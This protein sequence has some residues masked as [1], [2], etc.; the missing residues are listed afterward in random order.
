MQASTADMVKFIADVHLGRLA[1]ILRML[2]FDTVY[3]NSFP[4]TEMLRI[5]AAENRIVLSRNAALA[6]NKAAVAAFHIRSEDV[7][8]QIRSVINSFALEPFH[9][10]S[11]CMVCNGLLQAVKKESINMQLEEN[12]TEYFND[13]WQ[14]QNCKKIFWKGSHYEHMLRLLKD[15]ENG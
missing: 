6:K 7:R 1:R 12:T 2:G 11:R 9:P 13:F 8:E 10:F 14:C 3:S 15:L 4:A 5:A